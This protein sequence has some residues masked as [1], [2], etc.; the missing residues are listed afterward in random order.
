MKLIGQIRTLG[1]AFTI[2]LCS[3]TKVCAQ[4]KQ[5]AAPQSIVFESLIATNNMI[6]MTNAEFRQV[7]GRRLVFKNESQA[8]SF[9]ASELQASV[10]ERLN[11]NLQEMLARQRKMD[12]AKTAYN[13]QQRKLQQ[14]VQNN[15]NSRYKYG[16]YSK[17]QRALNATDRPSARPAV[18]PPATTEPQPPTKAEY[19]AEI[20]PDIYTT[21]QPQRPARPLV[22]LSD[23]RACLYELADLATFPMFLNKAAER[24]GPVC[25]S[26]DPADCLA[27]AEMLDLTVRFDYLA[28]SPDAEIRELAR[29]LR[30][31]RTEIWRVFRAEQDYGF[32]ARERYAKNGEK[33]AMWSTAIGIA[34]ALSPTP[35]S[36][37]DPNAPGGSRVVWRENDGSAYFQNA[38]SLLEQAESSHYDIW[39]YRI[40]IS[41]QFGAAFDE[42]GVFWQEKL[43]PRLKLLAPAGDSQQ[44]LATASHSRQYP[45]DLKYGGDIGAV[46]LCNVSGQTLSNVVIELK[47]DAPHWGVMPWYGFLREFPATNFLQTMPVGKRS[48]MMVETELDGFSHVQIR[49]S[50]KKIALSVYS[51]NGRQVD[52]HGL[53]DDTF[54]E[55][56]RAAQLKESNLPPLVYRDDA[57]AYAAASKK[58]EEVF[59]KFLPE[60][61]ELGKE[62]TTDYKPPVNPIPVRAKLKAAIVPGKKYR[63]INTEPDFASEVITFGP[64]DDPSGL[65]RAD[66]TVIAKTNALRWLPVFTHHLRGRLE[67][68]C[69]RG[70]VLAFVSERTRNWQSLPNRGI[71]MLTSPAN[72]QNTRLD[73]SIS[74]WY[75]DGADRNYQRSA[76]HFRAFTAMQSQQRRTEIAPYVI[77]LNQKGEL[78]I[79]IATEEIDGIIFSKLE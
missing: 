2:I 29:Q 53:D 61:I 59:A 36:V 41:L 10:L 16:G 68:E 70:C 77:Y 15:Q 64:L 6:L 56:E 79:Q 13:A 76:F 65:V 72:I 75:G 45:H 39:K 11:L 8:K 7:W 74:G 28:K 17:N 49:R 33:K 40:L 24:R 63:C 47:L 67:E 78:S 52:L 31:I 9:D 38:G 71:W 32:G 5:P 44:L 4:T 14:E 51:A 55:K 3:A 26:V 48:Q 21:P 57:Q 62:L 1:F 35:E 69:E 19:E 42:L 50:D 18:P 22:K 54:Y 25:W 27:T 30:E 20:T 12:E 66:L 34:T 60:A 23:T 46:S 58:I 73:Q 37:M 43:L